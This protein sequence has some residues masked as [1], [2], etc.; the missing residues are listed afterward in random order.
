MVL[1]PLSQQIKNSC[2]LAGD[3]TVESEEE[4]YRYQRKIEESL[5]YQLGFNIKVGDTILTIFDNLPGQSG[6]KRGR[7]KS[8][9][10]ERWEPLYMIVEIVKTI[11]NTNI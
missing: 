9:V 6:R 11:I 5:E 10:F 7:R 3:F 4:A 8:K 1:N 2:L